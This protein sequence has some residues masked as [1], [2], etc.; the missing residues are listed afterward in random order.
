MGI[1]LDNLKFKKI[2]DEYQEILEKTLPEAV[3]INARLLAVELARR[4]QPF[5]NNDKAKNIGETAI[6][7][8]LLGGRRSRGKGGGRRGIFQSLT[9]FMQDNALFYNTSEN[10]RLFARKDGSVYGTDR[11]HFLPDATAST[12]RGIHK[13]NFINGKVS[14]AGGD[15]RD[16]GRWKFINQYFVPPDVLSDYLASVK[17]KVGLAKS[18]WAA[19]A[20]QLKTGKSA[21]TRGIPG[22]VTKHLS[23]MTLGNVQD[24]TDN[25]AHPVVILTNTCRYIDKVC[26]E[27]QRLEALSNVGGRMKK[28][29]QTILKKRQTTVEEAA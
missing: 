17:A 12:M 23:D 16:I 26:P 2:L 29:M 1:K 18:G 14:A 8:D 24:H 25:K 5:G 20:K 9:P 22:W 28:Q 4:T 15:T 7:K 21:G 6:A 10:I 27:T 13:Q 19:C 3:R 11:A